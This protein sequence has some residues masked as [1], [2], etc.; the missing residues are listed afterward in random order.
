MVSCNAHNE[1]IIFSDVV[2]KINRKG[3]TQKRILMITTR[4]IYNLE[5]NKCKRRI[6]VQDIGKIISSRTSD[7]FILHIPKEYDYHY[8]SARS[9]EVVTIL[10]KVHHVYVGES[11]SVETLDDKD[12]TKFVLTK[13]DLEKR[14]KSAHM[15]RRS[16]AGDL[17]KSMAK[18]GLSEEKPTLPKEDSETRAV[19]G[20]KACMDDFELLK[21]LGKGSFGKVMQVK[22][23]D[24]GEILAMKILQ[25]DKVLE[26]HQLEHTKA[27]RHILQA[28]QHP[29]M[30]HLK[31]AFQSDTKLYMVLDY[32]NGGELFFHLQNSVRFSEVRARLYGAEI[33]LALGHLHSLGI[34]YRDLKPEN[35]LL[36]KDGHVRLT[37]FGLAKQNIDTNDSKTYTFCGTPEYLAPE[38]VTSEGHGR[39]VDWWSLGT[40]IYEM[41]NGLPPFYDPNMT[42]MYKKIIHSPLNFPSFFSASA[43]DLLSKLLERNP[44]KRLGSGETDVEEI[45]AHPFFESIDWDQLYKREVETPFKPQV[46]SDTDVQ[47]FDSCFTNEVARDSVVAPMKQSQEK[48]ANFDGFTF[49]PQGPLKR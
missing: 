41:M 28:V 33:L 11:L 16:S 4:A 17:M 20:E 1:K 30:V 32:V 47:N 31:Y 44:E 6:E 42:E 15:A 49:V 25:K 23:K 14:N 22:K 48:N 27:E 8:S 37:D 5:N 2:K 45:K 38:V 34:I 40:L 36:D 9:K 13:K 3:S 26:K 24:T 29:F 43:K 10:E 21:V 46:G 7:Q 12:L 35:I 18:M 19:F 39:G